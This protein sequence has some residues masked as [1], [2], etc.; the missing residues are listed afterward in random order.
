MLYIHVDND[1]T[2]NVIRSV[3]YYF[4]SHKKKEWFND[5]FVK[6]IIKEIDNTIAVKDEYMESPVFGGMSPDRLSTGCKALILMY[7]TDEI[8]F[9][10]RCGDN[11]APYILEIAKKKDLHIMLNHCMRFPREIPFDAIFVDSNVKTTNGLEYFKEYY[12]VR[13]GEYTCK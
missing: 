9:A 4:N 6:R 1:K 11:C 10:T 13:K 7:L 5:P 8:V 3:D 2:K 12:R